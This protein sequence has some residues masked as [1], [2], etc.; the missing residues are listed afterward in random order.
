MAPRLMKVTE[1]PLSDISVPK[2]RIRQISDVKVDALV[3]SMR[4]LG[5]MMHPVQLRK[6]KTGFTLVAGA[7]RYQAALRLDWVSIPVRAWADVTQEWCEIMELDENLSDPG[8]TT[9]D[10]AVFLARRKV[11]YERKHPETKHGAKGLEVASGSQTELSSVWSFARTVAEI[12]N[13]SDRQVR[14]IV[15]A[16]ETLTNQEVH[17]LQ[18][19]E[20]APTLADLECLA[21]IGD[22][23]VR[24][25]VISAFVAMKERKSMKEIAAR[26]NTAKLNA[27][28]PS[29]T[30]VLYQR[31]HQGFANAN[32]RAK[33]MFV[34][35]YSKELR[36]L[37]AELDGDA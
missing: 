36:Q 34:E 30:D 8:M 1:L 10:T 6:D 17:W 14:K 23:Q 21:S 16:G 33:R 20:H 37:L 7:H 28:K 35:H 32:K 25:S 3:A 18:K 24:H 19:S 31:A 4:E 2:D 11:I 29:K 15:K 13:I 27:P 22:A 26:W 9:L 5:V 12:L